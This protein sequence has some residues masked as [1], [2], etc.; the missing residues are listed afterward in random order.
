MSVQITCRRPLSAEPSDQFLDSD[1]GGFLPA[2]DG[3]AA[4]AGVRPEHDPLRAELGQPLSQQVGPGDGD[5]SAD[6]SRSPRAEHVA[7][8]L[9]AFDAA[10]V[11]HF[12]RGACG[13]PLQHA[14]IGRTGGFRPVQIDQVQT[15]CAA[16]L[17]PQGGVE[18]IF[19][20]GGLSVVV[21]L[22]EP[23]ALAS[24]QV[25]GGND[26]DHSLKKFCRMRSPTEALFSG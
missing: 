6:R 26:F 3:D 19:V 2:V 23:D 22:R 7:Q 15:S 16:L 10:A 12:E 20:I 25:D 14:E 8:R 13:D 11:L 21:A 17:V 24:D 4:V 18:R 5:A 9:G 1:C